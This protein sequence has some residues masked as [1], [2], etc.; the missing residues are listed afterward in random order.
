MVS[1]ILTILVIWAL[2]HKTR[3][4][5]PRVGPPG[6]DHQ[7]PGPTGPGMGRRNFP[8]VY[9][10]TPHRLTHPAPSNKLKTLRIETNLWQTAS[11]SSFLTGP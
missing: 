7:S 8:S 5:S 2:A 1:R 10:D 9:S 11:T 4:E 3:E 6:S